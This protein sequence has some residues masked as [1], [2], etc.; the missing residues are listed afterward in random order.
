MKP[1]LMPSA[2]GDPCW[3]R[4]N[5]ESQLSAIAQVSDAKTAWF[6]ATHSPVRCRATNGDLLVEAE[7]FDKLYQSA[8]PAQLAVIKGPPGAGKSQ[9]INWLRLR[10]EDALSRGEPRHEKSKRLR[11]V[12]IRRRSGSLKDALEQLVTQLPEYERFLDEVKTAIAQISDE[13]ARRKLSF[14]IS[15]VL[16]GLQQRGELPTDLQHLHQLFQDIRMSQWMCRANG[17]IDRNIQRLTSESDAQARESLPLFPPEE[18]DPR[19]TR[20]GHDVD[21]LMLDLLEE[22]ESL[23]AQAADIVNSVLR[24]ALAN[25]TGIKGQ[26]LHEVFREI[27]RAMFNAEE[28][29]ALFV[30]D[31]STMSILDEEL[32]NALEP[33]DEAG[34]CR[35]LSVLGMTVPAYNRL[36]ENMQERITLAL[37]IQGDLGQ[38][39][40]LADEMQTDRF[41]ARYLNALR[42]G[43]GQLPLLA[44]DRREHAE[45]RHSACDGC[46]LRE[47]CFDAFSSIDLGEVKVG[48]YP[49]ARGA[50][51]RLLQGLAAPDSSRNPRGLLRGIVLPLLETQSSPLSSR[52]N[53]FGIHLSPRAPSDLAEVRSTTLGG[54]DSADLNRLSYVTWYWTGQTDLASSRAS[55]EPMLPWLG[56]PAFTGE[57][58]RPP[59]RPMQPPP[60]PGVGPSV[61]P[62]SPPSPP[63]AL[64]QAK[65]RLQAWFDQK[66]TLTRDAEFRELLLDVVRNSLDEENVR[67]P[68]FAMQELASGGKPLN[69]ANI[70]IEGM[71]SNPAV[72]SKVR[73]R[74]KREQATYDLLNAL[75]DFQ[76][77][78]SR[79]WDFPG[80]KTQQR[81]YAKWLSH[82]RASML[83]SYHVVECPPEEAQRV[84]AAFLVLA[85]RFCRR[86]SLPSD[87]AAA[88]EALTSFDPVEPTVMTQAAGRLA[89]D[90]RERVHRVRHFLFAQLSV[91]Q[92]GARTL[93]FIDSR[94]LQDAVAQQRTATRLPV[95]ATA[96]VESDFP[97]VF[98]LG[99]SEWNR[100]PETLQEEHA[101]MSAVLEELRRVAD[102]WDIDPDELREEGDEL[103]RSMKVF[104][105]SARAAAKACV[106]AKQSMGGGDLQ[107]RIVDLPPAKVNAWVNCIAMAVE[108]EGAGADA[109]LAMDVG[110]LL[111]LRVFV[112]EVDQAMQQLAKDVEAQMAEV[113]TP[114]EVENERQRA[115]EAVHTLMVTIDPKTTDQPQE[116]ARADQAQ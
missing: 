96:S 53:S 24:E 51:F 114:A 22:E 115:Y 59:G 16:A 111:K 12:L 90:V 104:L 61:P 92:G 26:T 17:T 58:P 54:W 27:R 39:G 37:E 103:T 77:L 21:P 5:V 35:M 85:Y 97:D 50:A 10:F 71:Q 2:P 101:A 113:V 66:Q 79:S 6:L 65:Q 87:T 102:R 7:L 40:V 46:D 30:E 68:S 81:T 89:A 107:S 83:Q 82:H 110:P 13:Q 28:E 44:Q 38:T 99:K 47:K 29:L 41:V 4:A 19:G 43:E 67:T 75:L 11:T 109:M 72:G 94:A 69:N 18:F 100:L 112:R 14:E 48:L 15:V 3:T 9:L 76:H 1:E 8:S 56:L 80:G 116:S 95:L 62:T 23:R 98:R 42:V 31:V 88:V 84:A 32:V 36:P 105:Q 106:G 34:L 91:P 73:F 70:L 74:F 78:G 93:T 57:G 52:S 55:L 33:Q 49:L 20:R 63:A 45:I 25:V 64:E 60:R 86:S 108:A